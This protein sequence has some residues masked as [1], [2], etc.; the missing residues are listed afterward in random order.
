MSGSLH[1]L[2]NL[3]KSWKVMECFL[4]SNNDTP[5]HAGGHLLSSYGLCMEQ[6]Y[7]HGGEDAVRTPSVY[8]N[9]KSCE[10]Q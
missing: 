10:V 6:L 8:Q 9:K 1:S 4:L 5:V 2:E 7:Y 3:E